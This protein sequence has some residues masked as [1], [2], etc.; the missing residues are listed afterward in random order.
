MAGA[1]Y[2]TARNCQHPHFIRPV[3]FAFFKYADRE[4]K[5]FVKQNLGVGI[6]DQGMDEYV[7]WLT[8]M[9]GND[10]P[11]LVKLYWWILM[12]WGRLPR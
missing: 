2:H 8:S 11:N 5:E 1:E 4:L 7:D 10:A 3:L 12:F 6:W 9:P